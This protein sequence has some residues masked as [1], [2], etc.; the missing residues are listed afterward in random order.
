M[1]ATFDS[2]EVQWEENPEGKRRAMSIIT[3]ASFAIT[4]EEKIAQKAR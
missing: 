1:R 4:E 2:S 3:R